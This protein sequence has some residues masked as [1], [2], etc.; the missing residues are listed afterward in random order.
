M[1]NK[2][3]SISADEAV[4]VLNTDREHGLQEAEVK[5][6]LEKFGPN[7]FEKKPSFR[8]WKIIFA[9][10]KSPLVLILIIAGFV[11][12]LLNDFIDATVIFIAV[13]IN[14]VV[15]AF[16]EGRAS[17]AFDKMRQALKTTATAVRGGKKIKTD[18]A[19]LVPGDIILVPPLTAVAVVFKAWRILSN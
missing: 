2:W 1:Q 7:D 19:N 8:L 16:Q 12:I 15:G 5:A 18:T 3:H 10:I 14:T 4:S 17:K 6:R 13:G 11:S 9:Q